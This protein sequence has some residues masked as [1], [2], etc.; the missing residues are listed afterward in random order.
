MGETKKAPFAYSHSEVALEGVTVGLVCLQKLADALTIQYSYAT[1]PKYYHQVRGIAE[2][3]KKVCHQM[4]EE[5]FLTVDMFDQCTA[6]LK[7][8]DYIIEHAPE[9]ATMSPDQSAPND[10]AD[11]EHAVTYLH[12]DLAQ[13]TPEGFPFSNAGST[14]FISNKRM[15]R[16]HALRLN[17][18]KGLVENKLLEK[19]VSKKKIELPIPEKPTAVD[20][21]AV[22]GGLGLKEDETD[23]KILTGQGDPIELSMRHQ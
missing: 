4:L 20:L 19:S 8:L 23:W 16:H 21:A 3:I 11:A 9:G 12:V 7:Q 5:D 10:P 18:Q 6:I 15:R 14:A 1:F 22:V 2:M 17:L 13:K